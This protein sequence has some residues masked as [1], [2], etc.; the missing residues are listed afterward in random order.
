MKM[1][2]DVRREVYLLLMG[3]RDIYINQSWTHRLKDGED[4][5]P[6]CY[7]RTGKE[8]E[9]GGFIELSPTFSYP[10]ERTS[11]QHSKVPLVSL[12]IPRVSRQIYE[13]A[14]LLLYTHNT[15]HM[16]VTTLEFFM[17][18]RAIY[19]KQSL[20][21]LSI[22]RDFCPRGELK[23]HRECILL[24]ASYSLAGLR[25]LKVFTEVTTLAGDY[26]FTSWT[27]GSKIWGIRRLDLTAEF[28]VKA[29]YAD[30]PFISVWKLQ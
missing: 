6:K 3:N 14:R 16:S 28:V 13:E 1:P 7:L 19:R 17:D 24:T 18:R 10:T 22:K 20:R 30:D 27:E 4:S 8:T 2:Y 12:R 29:Q 9:V 15:L 23:L 11:S 21:S 26:D 5:K 25:N